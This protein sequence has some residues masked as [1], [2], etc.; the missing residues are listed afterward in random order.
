[1]FEVVMT[2]PLRVKFAGTVISATPVRKLEDGSWLMAS[3]VKHP[4]FD[5]GHTISI[6]EADFV[7]PVP[8]VS[9]AVDPK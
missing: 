7:D 3:C 1:M 9:D 4:R 2:N 8:E 5:I 6:P